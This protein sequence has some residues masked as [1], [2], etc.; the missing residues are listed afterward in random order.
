MPQGFVLAPFLFNIYL[1]DLFF[2]PECTYV[3]DLA[4]DTTFNIC[5]KDLNYLT[6]RLK[7]DSLHATELFEKSNIKLI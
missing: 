2:L 1:N 4:D 6:G 3:Y 5:D 7:H